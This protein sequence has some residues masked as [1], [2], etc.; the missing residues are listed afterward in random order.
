MQN[1][2]Y[3][4]ECSKRSHFLTFSFPEGFYKDSMKRKDCCAK[5]YF[6]NLCKNLQ[7]VSWLC[8]LQKYYYN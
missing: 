8:S 1:K 3:T 6:R 4:D 2:M 5:I 7:S